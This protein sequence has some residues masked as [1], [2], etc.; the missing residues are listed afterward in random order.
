RPHVVARRW[1][2]WLQR[3]LDVAVLRAD[4]AGVVIGQVDSAHWHT[5]VV[6]QRA[7]L[8]GRNDLADGLLDPGE[9]IGA[10]LDA[11][12][13]L[14]AHVHQD[15][16]RINRGEKIAA[17]RGHQQERGQNHAEKSAYERAAVT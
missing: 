13:H 10:V 7:Q 5:D 3:D 16:P 1:V 17:E 14:E 2:N 6:D 11:R 4:G 15:L 12:A 8:G 9:H